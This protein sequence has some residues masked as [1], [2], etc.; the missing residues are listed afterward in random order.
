MNEII[1]SYRKIIILT[2]PSESSNRPLV[3][4][5]ARRFDLTFNILKAQITPRKEGQM[6][7]E[8]SGSEENYAKG[9]AYLKEQGLKITPAAQKISRDLDSCIQCGMCTAIC[10]SDALYLNMATRE[11]VFDTE[12]C[13]ACGLCTRVCPVA[14]MRVEVENG[15]FG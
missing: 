10:P 6:T 5:L 15:D 11:V 3:C 14:A 12:R 2:F 7:L 8:L 13:A 9:I 1:K 4:D